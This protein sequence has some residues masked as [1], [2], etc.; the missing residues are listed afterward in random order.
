MAVN[1]RKQ[2]EELLRRAELLVAAA[3]E[4]EPL[5]L[6]PGGD[7]VVE[8]FDARDYLDLI[9]DLSRATRQRALFVNGLQNGPQAGVRVALRGEIRRLAERSVDVAI[10]CLPDEVGNNGRLEFLQRMDAYPTASVRISPLR[11]RGVFVFDNRQ[12][13]MWSSRHERNFAVITSPVV[14]EPILR[15]TDVLWETSCA[16]DVFTRHRETGLDET[17]SRVLRLLSSGCKDEVAARE[18]GFSVRTYRRHVASLLDALGAA[19]RFEAG[20]KAAALKLVTVDG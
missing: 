13:L 5:R 8:Y 7:K 17:G 2:I 15:L 6:A 16:L 18:L 1:H 20:V 9:M 19:S 12:A 11:V 3:F 14:L 10:T 4:N